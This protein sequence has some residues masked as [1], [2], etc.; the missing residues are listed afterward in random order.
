MKMD[1]MIKN[2][3]T[4]RLSGTSLELRFFPEAILR[5]TAEPIHTFDK[6]LQY[7]AD[8]MYDFMKTHRGIGLA[9]P[10]V[11]IPYRIMTIDMK[12]VERCLVNPV[13]DDIS[14]DERMETEGCLSLPDRLFIVD[15]SLDIKVSAWTPEGR[16]IHVEASGL[17]ARVIQHEIDHLNGILICDKGSELKKETES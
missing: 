6:V 1:E 9:A 7:I 16:R 14:V 10:Q 13:I 2:R 11:G 17:T 5:D 4:T 15:R 8:R 12:P 3:F